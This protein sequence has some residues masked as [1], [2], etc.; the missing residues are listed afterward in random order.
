MFDARRLQ[1]LHAVHV[2]GSVLDAAIELGLTSSAVSQQIGKLEREVGTP[3]LERAG[4]GVLLT[5]AARV[6]VDAAEEIRAAT[7]R[8]T[9]RLEDMRGELTGSLRLGCF[10]SAI[11]AFVAPA[12]AA[13]RREAPD[14]HVR[15]SEM[16]PER[17]HD[18]VVGGHVDIAIVHRWGDSPPTTTAGIGST[19]IGDDPVEILLHVDHPLAQRDSVALA[20][21]ADDIWVTDDLEDFCRNW[22]VRHLGDIGRRPRID[23]RVDELTAQVSL[24]AA[25]LCSGFLPRLALGR[26][27]AEVRNLPVEGDAPYRRV[28]ALYRDGAITRPAVRRFLADLDARLQGAHIVD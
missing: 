16:F 3:L 27:P 28:H 23:Y 4:R 26:L 17:A 1:C 18:A 13:L 8:A 20:D 19:V 7:D 6:L 10:P 22:L 21:L 5:D 24:I 15:L 25:G 14:L 12:L 11:E 9:A 2:H